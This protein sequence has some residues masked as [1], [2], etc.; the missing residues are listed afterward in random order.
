MRSITACAR[1]LA[2]SCAMSS[3]SAACLLHLP[4]LLLPGTYHRWQRPAIGV[5]RRR[6]FG[7]DAGIPDQSG[8]A[9]DVALDHWRASPSAP[10]ASGLPPA[11]R[12]AS[13]TSG[14]A[15]DRGQFGAQRCSTSGGVFAGAKRP[16]QDSSSS[17]ATPLSATSAGRDASGSAARR[18]SPSALTRPPAIC[19]R[20]RRREVEEQVDAAAEQVLVGRLRAAVR[21][22]RQL[23]ARQVPQRRRQHVLAGAVAGRGVGQL[24]AAS[25]S[26]PPPPPQSSNGRSLA[27][28]QRVAVAH[29]QAERLEVARLSYGR[30]AVEARVEREVRDR[31]DQQ[32]VAVGRGLGAR[33]VPTSVPEPGRFSTTK[34]WPICLAQA[35]GEEAADDVEAAAG[36]LRHDDACTGMCGVGALRLCQRRTAQRRRCSSDQS[37]SEDCRRGAR[38][39]QR[40]SAPPASQRAPRRYSSSHHR[41]LQHRHVHLDL[42]A[43]AGLDV[44]EM[45]VALG[46]CAS[47]C[48][49]STSCAAGSTGSMRSFS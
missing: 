36:R 32:R 16:N 3:V 20:R 28:H 29:R 11:L 4:D 30:F 34:L 49:S 7:G 12:K 35:I 40:S 45:A 2:S 5:R 22:M 44:G 46:K 6:S 26:P 21:H 9:R 8:P 1:S 39:C 31:A 47:A 18:S 27:R 10:S 38:P 37:A 13:L 43:D 24:A 48:G 15:V 14:A 19:R 23:D 41:A 17:C 33:S 25:P 42:V